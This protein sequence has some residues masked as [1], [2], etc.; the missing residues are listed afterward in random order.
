M[1][2]STQT[3][4]SVTMKLVR[5]DGRWQGGS[6]RRGRGTYVHLS[7]IH[8]DVWQKPTQYCKSNYSPIKIK[9]K[10]KER[11]KTLVQMVTFEKFNEN[12]MKK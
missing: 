11:K 2:Q 12:S 10:K 6:R 8:V 4:C 7:L 3:Q 1:T 9:L 5:W